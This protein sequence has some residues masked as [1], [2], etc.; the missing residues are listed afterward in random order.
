MLPTSLAAP[1][2]IFMKEASADLKFFF[3]R[4]HVTLR[5]TQTKCKKDDEVSSTAY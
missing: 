3:K 2:V 1:A 4:H 5:R